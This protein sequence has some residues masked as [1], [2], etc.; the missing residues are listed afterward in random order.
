MHNTPVLPTARFW[1]VANGSVHEAHKWKYERLG[2]VMCSNLTTSVSA[3]PEN[4][5]NCYSQGVSSQQSHATYLRESRKK[6]YKNEFERVSEL[7]Q[8]S[9]VPAHAC[10]HHVQ[11]VTS[12]RNIGREN[13]SF[14]YILQN[15]AAGI[16]FKQ[17]DRGVLQPEGVR[18]TGIFICHARCFDKAQLLEWC[19]RGFRGF[20]YPS[21]CMQICLGLAWLDLSWDKWDARLQ[22]V[23]GN[24]YPVHTPSCLSSVK[25]PF[26]EK[27]GHLRL[28]TVTISHKVHDRCLQL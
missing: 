21:W 13:N 10:V 18:R 4:I 20:L 1:L 9:C 11:Y 2:K 5:C 14:H 15:V 28:E 19:G 23:K 25:A 22:I 7:W 16:G 24:W 12:V 3:F 27:T 17:R 26:R 6:K 8:H